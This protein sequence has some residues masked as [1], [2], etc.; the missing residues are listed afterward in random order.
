MCCLVYSFT[1]VI[2]SVHD[3][4]DFQLPYFSTNLLV[5]FWLSISLVDLIWCSA[6]WLAST[7]SHAD[8]VRTPIKHSRLTDWLTNRMSNEFNFLNVNSNIAHK[9]YDTSLGKL[10]GV[11]LSSQSQTDAKYINYLACAVCLCGD[12]KLLRSCRQ[13][14]LYN[15]ASLPTM[16]LVLG[17]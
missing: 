7:K 6:W 10:L 13:Q 5:Y 3:T 17:W 11:V 8:W 12:G 9:T 14:I 15:Y 2:L 16:V 1:F 4:K